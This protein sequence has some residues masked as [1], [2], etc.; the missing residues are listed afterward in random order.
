MRDRPLKGLKILEFAGIG[1]GPFAGMLLSDLGADVVR[2]D[3][4]GVVPQ[5]VGKVTGRGRRSVAFDLKSAD[6]IAKVK[7][8]I[9][10]ADGLFEGFRP[11]VMERLGL[12][13]ST[14]L[15]INP[16]LVYGRITGWGQT[17]PLAQTAGH[18]I[19]YIAVAGALAS[20]GRAGEPPAPPLNLIGD[21]AGGALFLVVG[22]LSALLDAQKTGK[23][24]VVDAAMTDGT[25]LLM[26]MFHD[27][28]SLGLWHNKQGAN[29]LDGAA[30]FY[31]TYTCA[32]GQYLA[33]GAIEPHF[34]VQLLA[35]LGLSDNPLFASQMDMSK[36]PDMKAQMAEVIANK[37]Q[38]EWVA[39]FD[40]T[41]ACVA[42]VLSLTSAADHPHN[43]ERATFVTADGLLQPGAAPRF[44][45]V[46][47][48][49]ERTAPT[50]GQHT[51]EVLQEW[52]A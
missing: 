28:K 1:P 42:P 31:D 17:G 36:W 2:I 11:G 46:D 44:E 21:Y 10:K 6:D 37:T 45:G 13:P 8:L 4:P 38:S 52:L 25:A 40:K 7:Q 43:A 51:E 47:H 3:R 14:A 29:L 9:G 26:S 24:Q 22:V 20:M 41:D 50:P 34:Y 39:V 33:V 15:E 30:P 12:G 23:G 5:G 18:D 49:P 35:G 27:F 19:N 32:D 48:Q 16:K